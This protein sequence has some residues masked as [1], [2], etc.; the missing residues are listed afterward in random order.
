MDARIA[1]VMFHRHEI[2]TMAPGSR[3]GF[4]APQAPNPS[5]VIPARS[6]G[7]ATRSS[8]G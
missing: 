4:S 1:P 5:S 6:H 8:R 2:S 7:I 3:L